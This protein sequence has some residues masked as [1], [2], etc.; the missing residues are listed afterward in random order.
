MENFALTLRSKTVVKQYVG[1][2]YEKE[3][4]AEILTA[5]ENKDTACLN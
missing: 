2:R 5:I 4:L 3:L 1:Y